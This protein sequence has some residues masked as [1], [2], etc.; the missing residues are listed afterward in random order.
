MSESTING[1]F[2]ASCQVEPLY[3][4]L[5][6][7]SILGY[8]QADETPIA[9]LTKTSGLNTQR[10]PLGVPRSDGAPVVFDYQG[11]DAKARRSF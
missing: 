11:A 2:S 6:Q 1:W 5:W 7:S 8:L 3:H 9:V 4:S 10:L